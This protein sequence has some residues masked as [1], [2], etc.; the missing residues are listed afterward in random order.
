[1][2]R[3]LNLII[4]SI[5]ISSSCCFADT[6]QHRVTGEI[7]HGF[8]TQ[9][10][11]QNKTLIYIKEKAKFE[12]VNLA[13]GKVDLRVTTRD[14]WTLNPGI[15]ISRKGGENKTTVD[16]EDINLLGRGQLLRVS[17][18][19]NVDRLS[20]S[21][22]FEDKHVGNSWIA[23]N[24]MYADNSDGEARRLSVARPFFALDT[25]WSAGVHFSEFE[26][27]GVLYDLGEKAAEFQ[28]DR[29]F[30]S[31]WGGWWPILLP[32]RATRWPC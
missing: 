27:R 12:P 28:Q 9:K 23:L 1:M 10:T 26:E 18:T 19:D 29:N 6:F 13:D 4:I 2:R 22:E 7:F 16:I 5:I 17:R 21:I 30:L 8:A 14:V 31:A 24:A 20:K 32:N 15:S 11:S 3:A 25:H